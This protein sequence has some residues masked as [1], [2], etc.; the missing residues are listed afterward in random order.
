MNTTRTLLL[1]GIAALVSNAALAAS[2]GTDVARAEAAV[3]TASFNRTAA[4]QPFVAGATIA[5][6]DTDSARAAALQ[7]NS[8]Q[9]HDA[10]LAAVMNAGKT[11]PVA[12]ADANDID[13]WREVMH[14]KIV[15]AELQA[16]QQA[17]M[18][19]QSQGQ[20]AAR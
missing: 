15:A 9:L 6:I 13:G 3:Q 7:M 4:L 16:D 18:A 17:Y 19:M 12:Q 20:V 5:A 14:Q 10:H 1:A 2:Y 8:R 11:T